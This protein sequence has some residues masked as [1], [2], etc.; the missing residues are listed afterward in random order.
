MAIRNAGESADIKVFT[1]NKQ[2]A[3]RKGKCLKIPYYA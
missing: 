2:T 3:K 1:F